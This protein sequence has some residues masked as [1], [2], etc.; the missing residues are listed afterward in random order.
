MKRGEVW[1]AAAGSGYAGKP[2]PVVIIQDD[3]L[4]GRRAGMGDVAVPGGRFSAVSAG[5]F[6]TCGLRTD[7]AVVCW[8][9][10]ADGQA[11][12]PDGPFRAVSAGDL[13]TCGLRTDGTVSCWGWNE[14]GQADA[15]EG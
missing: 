12:A 4:S 15:P 9:N 13:H 7:S 1:T 10:N 8:G 11:D 3:P 6:H 14:F 2:R 5:G